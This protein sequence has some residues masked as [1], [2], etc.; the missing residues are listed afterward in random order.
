MGATNI[1]A[2]QTIVSGERYTTVVN[3]PK[4][5]VMKLEMHPRFSNV[6][7][8]KVYTLRLCQE[9]LVD[10]PNVEDVRLGCRDI[11]LVPILGHFL[12]VL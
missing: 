5:A 7:R 4:R 1:F 3:A 9:I 8:P 11:W 12:K 10:N 6:E 2:N